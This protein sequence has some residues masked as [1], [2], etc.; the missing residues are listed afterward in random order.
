[1]IPPSKTK[2]KDIDP[3]ATGRG[4]AGVLPI[5]PD[6]DKALTTLDEATWQA[7]V[8][9]YNNGRER[10]QTT[11]NKYL[12]PYF[13]WMPGYTN[14]I[15][16]WPGHGKS[17]FFFE[18]LLARAVFSEKMS[19]VFPSENMPPKRFFQGLIHTLTGQP[20]DK[21]QANHLS[22]AEMKR[23]ADFIRDHFILL[24]PPTGMPFTPAAM[25]AYAERAIAKHGG[26]EKAKGGIAHVML[27]PWN[28]QDHSGKMKFG[29][30]EGYLTHAIGLCTKWSVDTN[31]CLVLTAHPK[32]ASADMDFGVTRPVP[33]GASISGGQMWENM[34]HYLGAVHR[35][36]KHI[37]GNTEAA[38]YSH[39]CKDE[40]HVA[41]LGSVGGYLNGM[42]PST[43]INWDEISNRYRWGYERFTPFDDALVKAIYATPQGAPPQLFTGNG[44]PA[45]SPAAPA[46]AQPLRT[47]SEPGAG[48]EAEVTTERF[49]P[50]QINSDSLSTP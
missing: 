16:G 6:A 19:V 42:Q 46:S 35:P 5:I 7:M 48:F 49:G 34:P 32:R 37:P 21:S 50:R 28:K 40:R 15:T 4:T 33:D 47:A 25:L 22:L 44:Q 1:M 31:Q 18:Q 9:E 10:G 14:V 3:S 39:K 29:G 20:A 13:S 11:H 41:K 17:Q 24:N 23:A 38:F 26:A 12:N 2:R 8:S 30:D 45:Q 36:F 27:D 43:P